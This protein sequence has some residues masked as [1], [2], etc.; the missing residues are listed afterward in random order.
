MRQDSK[1]SEIQYNSVFV[2]LYV[3]FIIL[4]AIAIFIATVNNENAGL[5]I[6]LLATLLLLTFFMYMLGKMT[7]DVTD[8]SLFITMGFNFTTREFSLHQIENKSLKIKKLPKRFG[9]GNKMASSNRTF[10]RIGFKPCVSFKLKND[11]ERYFVSSAHAEK[12][13]ATLKN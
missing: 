2:L 3:I 10:F 12:L 8:Q 5:A 11:E 7:I 9:F 1:Y 6:M 4:T 13:L